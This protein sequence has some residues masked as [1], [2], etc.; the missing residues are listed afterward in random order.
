CGDADAHRLEALL[1]MLDVRR[2]DHAAAR[3]LI[4]DQF[5]RQVFA[6]GDEVHLVGDNALAGGFELGHNVSPSF[7]WLLRFSAAFCGFLPLRSNCRENKNKAAEKRR[8]PNGSIHLMSPA[9][10]SRRPHSTTGPRIR[11]GHST[12]IA[13]APADTRT[14]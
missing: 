13:P 11:S 10:A 1:E 2:N 14:A 7:F 8:S 12:G 9:S 6:L 5:R 4:A 3:H